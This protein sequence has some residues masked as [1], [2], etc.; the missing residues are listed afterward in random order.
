MLRT[1]LSIA[2][3]HP[4]LALTWFVG[5]TLIRLVQVAWLAVLLAALLLGMSSAAAEAAASDELASLVLLVGS[6]RFL[7]RPQVL[8]GVG[9]A[10]VVVGLVAFGLGA[11]LR[12]GLLTSLAQ[13]LGPGIA[14]RFSL[15][16]FLRNGLGLLDRIAVL[17]LLQELAPWCGL[18]FAVP[19]LCGLREELAALAVGSPLPGSCALLLAASLAGGALLALALYAWAQLAMIEV[20]LRPA[21]P[22]SRSLA[23]SAHGLATALPGLL[24]FALALLGLWG[25]ALVG[26]LL[27]STLLGVAGEHLPLLLSST[28]RTLFELFCALLAAYLI[29]AGQM[30][31]ILL[32]SRLRPVPRDGRTAVAGEAALREQG[33]GGPRQP[34]PAGEADQ[35]A[36]DQ[37]EL[38]GV[39]DPRNVFALD[40]F[41]TPSPDDGGAATAQGGEAPP[42]VA[43]GEVSSPL[44]PAP[45]QGEAPPP[46]PPV[47]EEVPTDTPGAKGGP[48]R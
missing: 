7:L 45:A 46:A 23:E 11:L 43:P 19:V 9:G 37:E 26:Y 17:A 15:R 6:I 36:E 48:P 20:V 4:G 40:D 5:D 42:P 10:Y 16:A 44:H 31:L 8:V 33:E 47:A 14:P 34:G 24:S 22:L 3:R 13:Q 38:V 18:A 2:G 35:A 29:V 21:Q 41:L 1:G 27:G 25:L 28:G 39:V 32:Y 12:S 30:G